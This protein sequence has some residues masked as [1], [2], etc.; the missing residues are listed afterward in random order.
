MQSGCL[1]KGL[2]HA[3]VIPSRKDPVINWVGGQAISQA[4]FQVTTE[5]AN[6][7]GYGQ[8]ALINSSTR[9]RQIA[10]FGDRRA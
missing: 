2:C 5:F 9:P 3:S 8:I 4:V 1:F 10:N 6:W 7:A